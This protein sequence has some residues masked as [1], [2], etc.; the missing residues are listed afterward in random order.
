MSSI[1]H[2]SCIFAFSHHQQMIMWLRHMP[3]MSPDLPWSVLTAFSDFRSFL[4]LADI[5]HSLQH[6]NLALC[7]TP[8]KFYNS[9]HSCRD[10]QNIKL[11]GHIITI[12]LARHWHGNSEIS[13]RTHDRVKGIMGQIWIFLCWTYAFAFL[14]HCLSSIIYPLSSFHLKI[15]YNIYTPLYI[16]EKQVELH[17]SSQNLVTTQISSL[18]FVLRLLPSVLC[19][20]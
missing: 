5:S 16:P 8:E 18:D 12:A 20:S 10:H 19:I 13:R 15:S 7:R 9:V 1:A 3:L 11:Q 2:W 14:V 6:C 4:L 17:P